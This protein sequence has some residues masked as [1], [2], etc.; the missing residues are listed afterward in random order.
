[1][2]IS[3]S[4]AASGGAPPLRLQDGR[5]S[6]DVLAGVFMAVAGRLASPIG[7]SAVICQEVTKVP[8]SRRGARATEGS[9]A[10]EPPCGAHVAVRGWTN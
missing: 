8:T 4:S 10:F 9:L 2:M 1:M 3:L 5:P 6:V 7:R